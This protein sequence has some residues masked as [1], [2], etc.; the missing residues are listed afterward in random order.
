MKINFPELTDE[1]LDVI[2]YES[3]DDIV[4][5]LYFQNYFERSK[6][7]IV[8]ALDTPSLKNIPRF[9]IMSA[10]ELGMRYQQ[11]YGTKWRRL[12]VRT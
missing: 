3:K 5:A 4:G 1:K 10:F 6:S 7:G 8:K 9:T 12:K 11:K 2:V